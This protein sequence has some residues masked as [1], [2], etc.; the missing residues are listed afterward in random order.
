MIRVLC[1]LAVAF[2]GLMLII[3]VNTSADK[4]TEGLDVYHDCVMENMQ[5]T[6]IPLQDAWVVFHDVCN[7]K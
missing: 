7:Q 2:A 6:S 5:G 4:R 1:F 3:A